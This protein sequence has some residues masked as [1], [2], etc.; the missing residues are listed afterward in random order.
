MPR[1][2]TIF[3]PLYIEKS[4]YFEVQSGISLRLPEHVDYFIFFFFIMSTFS[5]RD[6][7]TE[8]SVLSQK[9]NPKL[10]SLQMF[11]KKKTVNNVM[12]R[13]SHLIYNFERNTKADK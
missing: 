8:K 9:N 3:C 4:S 2:Q 13:N 11:D 10:Q 6:I 1:V 12:Y 7:K 5:Y